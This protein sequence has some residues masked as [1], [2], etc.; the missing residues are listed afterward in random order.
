MAVSAALW[1]TAMDRPMRLGWV[2][3]RRSGESAIT[4]REKADTPEWNLIRS[5]GFAAVMAFG[6]EAPHMFGVYMGE[7]RTE[8]AYDAEQ[9][10]IV[11]FRPISRS[12]YGRPGR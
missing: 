12:V 6:L 4:Y 11:R 7:L 3:R 10:A 5:E 8:L 1:R 2:F 9:E